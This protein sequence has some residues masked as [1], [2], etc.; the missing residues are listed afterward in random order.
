MLCWH[1]VLW[2]TR[3]ETQEQTHQAI[4]SASL[5]SRGA[6]TPMLKQSSPSMDVMASDTLCWTCRDEQQQKQQ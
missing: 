4:L 5:A 1:S 6:A 3:P 2:L